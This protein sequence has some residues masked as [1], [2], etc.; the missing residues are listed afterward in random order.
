MKKLR[1]QLKTFWKKLTGRT[2]L[3]SFHRQQEKFRQ[4]YPH[5]EIGTATYGMPVVHDLNEGTTLKIGAYSSIGHNVQ[6]FLGGHHRIDWVS[7]YPFPG[8]FEEA[9]AIKDYGGSR[10]NVIVGSDVWLCANCSILSGVTVGHGAVVANGAMVTRDVPPYAV[11]AGNPAKI[12]K[13]RFDENTR[14]A[15]LEYAWWEWPESEIRQI[16]HL[17]CSENTESF[18]DYAKRRSSP[19][20]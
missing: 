18:I 15:M 11:V 5:Y 12:I 9:R 7:S 17:L 1:K 8:F 6:I 20:K 14:L 2:D 19:S 13:W 16:T 3:Q 4:R 10:G